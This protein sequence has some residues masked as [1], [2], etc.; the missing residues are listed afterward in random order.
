MLAPPSFGPML[1]N[2]IAA[3]DADSLET[4]LG[5]AWDGSSGEL[6]NWK[7]PS[8]V[9]ARWT[10]GSSCWLSVAATFYPL[11]S[12]DTS[13]LVPSIH[14]TD[15]PLILRHSHKVTSK[16]VTVRLVSTPPQVLHGRR[17]EVV[18]GCLD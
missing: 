7:S 2:P 12:S 11:Q 18:F 10:L 15:D 9:T 17:W 16:G 6:M 3:S 13:A 1:K 4:I 14:T 8:Y 5:D